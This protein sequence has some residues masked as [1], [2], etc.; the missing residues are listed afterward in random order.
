MISRDDPEAL[1]VHGGGLVLIDNK[2]FALD[3]ASS[4]RAQMAASLWRPG[5]QLIFSGGNAHGDEIA[6][7]EAN[8]MADLAIR[9]GVPHSYVHREPDSS[10]TIGNW[11]NSVRILNDLEVERVA[12]VTGSFASHRARFIGNTVI[13]QYDLNLKLTGYITSGETE[14]VLA[15]PREV[16]AFML[17]KWCL[18]Q[19]AAQ[20]I[21]PD[22]LNNFFLDLKKQSGIASLKRRVSSY[23]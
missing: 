20:D 19:A 17:A 8:L 3:A 9:E 16:S 18:R 23:S 1:L 14:G 11:G 13:S 10:S 5:R 22:Q 6:G 2:H 7:S 12:G 4:C 15:I 21:K